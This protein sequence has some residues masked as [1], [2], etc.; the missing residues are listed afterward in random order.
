[1]D[2]VKFRELR[3]SLNSGQRKAVMIKDSGDWTFKYV[4]QGEIDVYEGW[5]NNLDGIE[6]NEVS[7]D[8]FKS[9]NLLGFI[10]NHHNCPACLPDIL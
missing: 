3:D 4:D 1:M 9:G 6:Y 5:E 8:G 10:Y 7:P 2:P